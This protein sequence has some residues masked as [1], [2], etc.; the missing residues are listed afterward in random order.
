MRGV[1]AAGELQNVSGLNVSVCID[2]RE[3]PG[4]SGRRQHKILPGKSAR[5]FAHG[6]TAK[7]EKFIFQN[8]ST[9]TS[10]KVI[11]D[12]FVP[13][14]R[15]A[16]GTLGIVAPTIRIQRGISKIFVGAAVIGICP[17][18]GDKVDL[19]VGLTVP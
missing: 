1:I 8:R 16:R 5:L 18:A 17:P 12:D 19:H 2:V 4:L 7:N 3:S 11:Q 15:I 9:D 14:H 6:K 13:W 10:A